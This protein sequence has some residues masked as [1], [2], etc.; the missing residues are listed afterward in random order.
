MKLEHF[1]QLGRVSNLP[2]VWSNVLAATA[3]CGASL[4]RAFGLSI[5]LSLFYVGGMFLNDVFDARY[6]A[7][8]RPERPIP[9]GA[10]SFLSAYLWGSGLLLAGL[11]GV[12]VDVLT[13]GGGTLRGALLS[14]SILGA[15]IVLYNAWHKNNPLSPLIMGG[16]RVAVYTTTALCLVP[17][18]PQWIIAASLGLLSYLIGLT[19]AAKQENL[20]AMKQSWPLLFLLTPLCLLPYWSFGRATLLILLPFW[21]MLAGWILRSSRLLIPGAGKKPQIPQAVGSLIAGI[22]LW[23]AALAGATGAW[24]IALVSVACFGATLLAHRRVA[25]T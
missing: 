6:D 16:C 11:G 20:G 23:D 18:L 15:L 14:G 12:C 7:E 5:A 21:L 1:L 17:A 3:L 2:T 8:H 24:P 13:F 4:T 22:S 10:V 19:Y 9:S 25:G